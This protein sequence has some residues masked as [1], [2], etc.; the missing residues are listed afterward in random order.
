MA[1]KQ[2]ADL[3]E[4]TQ[5]QVVKYDVTEAAIAKMEQQYMGL[6]IRGLDD[7]AGFDMVHSARM[8]VK[9]HRVAVETK[10]K[11]LKASALEWGKKVDTEAKRIVALL[12]PIE[13]HLQDEEDRITEEKERIKAEKAQAEQ[14]RI[15][16]IQAKIRFI[17]SFFLPTPSTTSAKWQ[18]LSDELE[19][20]IITPE[21]YQEFTEQANKV[22]NE[23]YAAVQD[24]LI[25]RMKFEK[26]ED[27]RKAEAARLA[28]QKAEQEAEATRLKAEQDKIDVEKARLE[29][30]KKAEEERKAREKR[31]AEIREEEQVK[32]E[33]AAQE[34]AERETREKRER[35]EAEAK[36]KARQAAVTPDRDKLLALAQALSDI[37]F[38]KLKDKKAQAILADV[39][40][41]LDHIIT[42]IREEVKT[43]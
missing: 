15:E 18:T 9:T 31:E 16:G 14:K 8:V 7:K 19:K 6:M 2:E 39:G 23:T 20:V 10:R 24:A 40:D 41:G 43:L 17:S 3:I 35:E 25:A 37:E 34:K 36:E 11:E 22:L 32:A 42:M 29:S 4:Y 30:E 21:E 33:K 5:M 27:D 12:E 38:P 28:K 1:K 13:T 26:E